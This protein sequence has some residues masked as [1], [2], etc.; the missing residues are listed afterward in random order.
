MIDP[1][2][3]DS[4]YSGVVDA[5][6]WQ[7]MLG[8]MARLLDTDIAVSCRGFQEGGDPIDWIASDRIPADRLEEVFSIL[9]DVPRASSDT[10]LLSGD[11][12][13]FACAVAYGISDHRFLFG[14]DGRPLH[15]EIRDRVS[16]HVSHLMRAARLRDSVRAAADQARNALALLDMLRI[17]VMLV[18]RQLRVVIANSAVQK[19][20][21][22]G[23][24]RLA[25]REYALF[26]GT[27]N[28]AGAAGDRE[29]RRG[30]G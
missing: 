18:N 20:E 25:G 19:L 14:C 13:R 27:G 28:G 3:L 1:R 30:G 12:A 17:P 9:R 11:E 15:P 10:V 24:L 8:V 2:V 16:L 6:G 23:V 4:I 29:H 21:K 22:E 7:G 26:V 5:D